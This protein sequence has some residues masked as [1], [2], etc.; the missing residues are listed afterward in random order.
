MGDTP[1]PNGLVYYV[2]RHDVKF[3]MR[4]VDFLLCS[5]V[6]G[7]M[8][9]SFMLHRWSLA[10]EK[11][12]ELCQHWRNYTTCRWPL[13]VTCLQQ[14]DAPFFKWPLIDANINFG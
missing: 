13:I 2:A 9:T 1:V 11:G 14:G 6:P 5:L 12:L 4:F 10:P 8:E 7:E 3:I